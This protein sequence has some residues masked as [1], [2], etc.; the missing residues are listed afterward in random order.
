MRL[1]SAG[2]GVSGRYVLVAPS[3]KEALSILES[4]DKPIDLVFTDVVMPG[5]TGQ[6]LAEEVRRRY[7]GIKLLFTSGY[8]HEAIAQHGM[9]AAEIRLLNKPYTMAQLTATIRKVLDG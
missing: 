5:M 4:S 9:L 1:G 8:A 2:F 6:A 3:G 7:P